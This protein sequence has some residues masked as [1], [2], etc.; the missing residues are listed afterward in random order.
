MIGQWKEGM[1][2]NVLKRRERGARE[3]RRRDKVEPEGEGD[4]QNH[5]ILG[6]TSN[7]TDR[8]LRNASH[9]CLIKMCSLYVCQLRSEF[10]VWPS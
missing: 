9:T 10:F 5:M 7:F 1:G 8:R 2:L 4:G 6:A 3:D